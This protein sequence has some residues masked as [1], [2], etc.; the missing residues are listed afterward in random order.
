MFNGES[1]C[2][3][4]LCLHTNGPSTIF[5]FS[6]SSEP[7]QFP[8]QSSVAFFISLW[9]KCIGDRDY[10]PELTLS[11]CM[12]TEEQ[13]LTL[14]HTP[15][16]RGTTTPPMSIWAL[17]ILCHWAKC[18]IH[19][20]SSK[21]ATQGEKTRIRS[22]LTSVGVMSW[23]LAWVEKKQG[24]PFTH[25]GTQEKSGGSSNADSYFALISFK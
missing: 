11:L 8:L 17:L 4:I 20:S 10:A 5:D 23:G 3:Q 22:F 7:K 14:R 25:T 13:A 24:S 1:A 9:R 19:C 12:R 15:S 16:A 18:L 2:F 21:P 6:A